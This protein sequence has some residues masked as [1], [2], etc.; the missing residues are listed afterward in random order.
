MVW[1]RSQHATTKQT[2]KQPSLIVGMCTQI[3]FQLCYNPRIYGTCWLRRKEEWK[4][5]DDT[6]MVIWTSDEIHQVI[7]LNQN[8]SR[9]QLH[10]LACINNIHVISSK[11][12]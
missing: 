6:Q 12:I 2:N 3:W 10:E 11:Y 9:M 8:F 7:I 1:G 5:I 4:R